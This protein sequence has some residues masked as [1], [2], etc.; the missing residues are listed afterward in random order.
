[1]L[2]E[3]RVKGDNREEIGSLTI[4]INEYSQ[5]LNAKEE[6][7]A[8]WENKYTGLYTA[9]EELYTNYNLTKSEYEITI[10]NIKIY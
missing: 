4:K 9:Y 7:V 5:L 1:M 3:T 6:D 8:Y 2:Q 10:N